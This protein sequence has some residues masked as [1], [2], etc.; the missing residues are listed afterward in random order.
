MTMVLEAN[1]VYRSCAVG[2]Y[3]L[4]L[5]SPRCDRAR[6]LLSTGIY[7]PLL[8]KL[9]HSKTKQVEEEEYDDRSS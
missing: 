8:Q 9:I 5:Q 4:Q 3:F 2:A 1:A 7:N 6:K